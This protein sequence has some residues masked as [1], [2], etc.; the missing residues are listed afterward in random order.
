MNSTILTLVFISFF[1]AA[2]LKGVTGLGFVTLCL[3]FLALLLDLKLAIALVILPSLSSNIM[4]MIESGRFIEAAKRFWL[5]YIS[6][7]PG[8]ILGIWLLG[9]SDKDLP[10]AILGLVMFLY[11]I[12]GLWK[13]IMT[14][15]KQQEKRLYFPI[16]FTSGVVNG[17]TGSQIMP[18]MPYLLSLNMD[19]NLF[20]QTINTSFTINMIIMLFG[21]NKLG[22]ITID[23]M[24][25]SAIGIIPVAGGIWLGGIVRKKVSEQFYRKMV[26]VLLII[27]GITLVI[28]SL[29]T[30][31]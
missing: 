31:I 24:I 23:N 19:R 29:W 18:I 30:S 9:E 26:L 15:S 22:M 14:I 17:V 2:F 21:L 20:I 11:G 27:L 16:G 8:L 1:L 10:R 7:L 28:R 5:L 3:G 6:A 4:V 25:I 12:Y 13:G